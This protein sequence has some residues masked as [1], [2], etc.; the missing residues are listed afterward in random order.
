MAKGQWGPE[1]MIEPIKRGLGVA[2]VVVAVS[3]ASAATSERSAM[4]GPGQDAGAT[5]SGIN[6][7]PDPVNK[8]H[9]GHMGGACNQQQQDACTMQAINDAGARGQWLVVRSI[10]CE[11]GP[12]LTGEY[13][14][15]PITY[16]YWTTVN[17]AT[18]GLRPVAPPPVTIAH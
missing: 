16:C 9:G 11:S 4:I 5:A 6:D 14:S 10:R 8:R 17:P 7:G 18:G 2:L 1:G 3:A 13:M 12:E 15:G